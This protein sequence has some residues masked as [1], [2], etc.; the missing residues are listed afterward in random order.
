MIHAINNSHPSHK[1]ASVPLLK[2]NAP[3][4]KFLG[5]SEKFP[6][7]NEK[8]TSRIGGGRDGVLTNLKGNEK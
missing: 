8:I 2:K 6:K 1:S 5:S 4:A 7:L 3:P